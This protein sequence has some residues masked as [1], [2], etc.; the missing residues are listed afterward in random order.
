MVVHPGLA[1]TP[2]HNISFRADSLEL[3]QYQL[4]RTPPRIDH[5][6]YAN[7]TFSLNIVYIVLHLPIV[8]MFLM[9][10]MDCCGSFV[11]H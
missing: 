6:Y 10:D 11:K 3:Q 5:H 7:Y 2:Q 4:Q 9:T 8:P 1:L